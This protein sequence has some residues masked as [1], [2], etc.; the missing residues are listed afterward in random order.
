MYRYYYPKDIRKADRIA[1]D[2]LHYE[3]FGLMET[4]GRNAGAVVLTRNPFIDNFVIFCGPGNNGG[5]GFVFADYMLEHD[6]SVTVIT[7][8]PLF[9]YQGDAKTA[10]DTVMTRHKD[11]E[12][13]YIKDIS[14]VSAIST[15]KNTT[16]VVDA[17]LG[18]GSKDEPRG[19]IKDALN[20]MGDFEPGGLKISLDMPTGV[21]AYNGNV[22]ANAFKADLTVTFLAMKSGMAFRKASSYCGKIIVAGIGVPVED[23]LNCNSSFE[24]YDRIDIKTMLP[25]FN[26]DIHKGSRGSVLIYGG[27]Y[28]YRGAPLLAGR[29]SL[30]SGAGVVYMAVPDYMIDSAT[31]VLPEA[32]FIPLKTARGKVSERYVMS[33]LMPILE[34]VN[35]IVFGPGVG[36]D[37]S[38]G[39]IL[40]KI[41]IKTTAKLIIDAD[42][43][44]FVDESIL[45]N[46][47]NTIITPH[48]G[49]AARILNRDVGELK[50]KRLDTVHALADR[51]KVTCLKGEQTLIQSC[52]KVRMINEGSA[53]LAVPG[54]GDVLTGV[55]ATMCAWGLNVFDATTLGV[56]LHA[57]AGA[58]IE[59]K[60]GIHGCLAREIADEIRNCF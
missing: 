21:N 60:Y 45:L 59:Q 37:K 6:K 23:V 1:I 40:Q 28:N 35:T 50:D 31:V 16:C 51:Y 11:F 54:S 22:Y 27:S 55:I 58:N 36:L 25:K 24:V 52:N 39:R 4:A 46:R 30:R 41:A 33:E 2:T 10:L 5:D 57:V 42:A 9:E 7:T 15:M 18:T 17:L 43:L 26:S 12:I 53:S 8:I 20:M 49:E 29:G 32:V 48:M 14:A 13:L 3:S 44:S 56:V 47:D 34:K 19:T 38:V